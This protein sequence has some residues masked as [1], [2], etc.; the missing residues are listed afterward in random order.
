MSDVQM[1]YKNSNSVDDNIVEIGL[2]T[3]LNSL[4]QQ[5]SHKFLKVK[6]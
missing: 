1:N 4:A 2:T 5:S 3:T 6:S